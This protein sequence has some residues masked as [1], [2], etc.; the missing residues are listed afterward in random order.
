MPNDNGIKKWDVSI[1]Y[2]EDEDTTRM[3]TSE[4][5]RRRANTLYTANNGE[6]GLKSFE[7]Y[8][9]D[10]VLTD[11]RMP[12]MD[13]IEM[14]KAIKALNKDAR[15]IILTAYDDVNYLINSIGIGV[16]NYV[17]KPVNTAN[18]FPV[19]E[20]C[21]HT[22]MLERKIHQQNEEREKLIIELQNALAKVKSLTGL[23]PICSACKKIRDD[24]GYWEQIEAYISDHAEVEFSHGICPECLKKLYPEYCDHNS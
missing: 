18:L 7:Q 1:L 9:P 12:A 15:I 16:N 11:I 10:I 17:L 21:V 8:S 20:G 22:I 2:V 5:L 13:G 3:L 24:K 14:S 19:I 6:E 23:L 4:I